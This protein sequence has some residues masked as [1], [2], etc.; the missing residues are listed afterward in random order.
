MKMAHVSTRSYSVNFGDR[1]AA[2]VKS[3]QET[4]ARRALYRRTIRELNLLT[5]RD[6]ADLGVSRWD[7]PALAR[8]AAY[9]SK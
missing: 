1:I 2:L 5:D 6:L 7:I 4:V 9:G 3:V 8:E